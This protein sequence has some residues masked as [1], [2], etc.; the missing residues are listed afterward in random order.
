MIKKSML[1]LMLFILLIIFINI[2]FHAINNIDTSSKDYYLYN[3]YSDTGS[4]N[5]VTG[6]YLDYRLFDSIFEASILII[7]VSGIIFM[8]KKDDEVL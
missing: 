6:I 5:I 8:S 7:A 4:K 1:I 3:T 2:S